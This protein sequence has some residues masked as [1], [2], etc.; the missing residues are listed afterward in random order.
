M[1]ID[2]SA[3]GTCNSYSFACDATGQRMFYA[4]CLARIEKHRTE[5]LGADLYACSKG[6]EHHRC[7]A[8][9]MRSEEVNAGS[10][11]YFQERKTVQISGVGEGYT[12]V[13]APKPVGDDVLS[14]IESAVTDYSEVIN[15]RIKM[16]ALEVKKFV[17]EQLAAVPEA[18]KLAPSEPHQIRPPMNP[19]ESLLD[20][21]RRISHS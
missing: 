12:P 4:A 11:I 21:A 6:I 20:Y 19:G 15:R 9:S 14:E 7:P 5:G 1:V 10:A 16:A 13:V 2:K 8:K 17:A 3:D 18:V